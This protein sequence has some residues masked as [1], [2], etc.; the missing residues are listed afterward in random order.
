MG[1]TTLRRRWRAGL[2]AAT[3]VTIAACVGADP[4]AGARHRWWTGLGPVLP[5]ESFPADCGICHEGSGWN[6]MRADFDFDH[7]KETGVALE[8]AHAQ[9]QCL[10]CHNDRGP[11]DVFAAKGCGGCHEDVHGGDLGS[12]CARCH[13]PD[14]WQPSGQLEAHARSRFPLSG[15]HSRVA[16]HQC[17]PGAFVGNFVPNDPSCV[18]CHRADLAR[19]NNPPHLALGFVDRCDRCHLPTDWRLAESK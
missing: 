17:H 14:T 2:F 13:Q 6:T 9:A 11:V 18:T 16:C 10:R 15:A 1:S 19:A 12:D 7:A 3:A 4:R 5:H 8:G